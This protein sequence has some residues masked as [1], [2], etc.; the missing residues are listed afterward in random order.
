MSDANVKEAFKPVY[1]AL[2][3]LDP[4]TTVAKALPQVVHLMQAKGSGG[5]SHAPIQENGQV[6]AYYCSFFG[7]YF[8]V[9]DTE[10]N[11]VFAPKR[12]G[13][14]GVNSYSN[15]GQRQWTRINKEAKDLAERYMKEAREQNMDYDAGIAHV[16]QAD[17]FKKTARAKCEVPKTYVEVQA[18]AA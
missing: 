16:A 10:G 13:T 18:P 5:Q 8:Q 11:P 17:K 1:N 4:K 7:R 14:H 6:V 9:N 12:T 3:A 2:R 15:E